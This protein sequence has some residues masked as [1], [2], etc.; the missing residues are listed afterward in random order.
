VAQACD[1]VT[2]ETEIGRIKFEASLGKEFVSP[3]LNQLQSTSATLE[4]QIGE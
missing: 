3:H 1:A 2:Q 4:V